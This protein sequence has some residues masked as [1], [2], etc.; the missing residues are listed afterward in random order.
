MF[1][2]RALALTLLVALPAKAQDSRL[3]SLQTGFAAQ[4][5]EAIGRLDMQGVGFCTATLIAPDRILTA[6]HCLY[7][8]RTGA[9]IPAE[10]L[11]FLAG[12]RT[13]RAEAERGINRIAI[14][15]RFDFASGAGMENV[16]EDIA[17]LELDRP[18][19]STTIRPFAVA[20]LPPLASGGSVTVVSY[21]RNRAEAPSI[22]ESCRILQQRPDG[23]SVFS[24]EIDYGSSGAP[25]LA[26]V[27]GERRIVSV[28]SARVESSDTPMSLGMRFAG[29]ELR[30]A[31]GARLDLGGALAHTTG[32]TIS[33]AIPLLQVISVVMML[34]GARGQGL[35]DAFLG[36]VA[37][38][39]RA[40]I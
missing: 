3:Q 5:W 35:T 25:V 33:L 28:I 15:P 8:R 2:I 37:L 40:A 7:D 32:Y 26:M 36:T 12:W 21:A 29:I 22:Q 17:V 34:T 39:R 1:L 19:R 4:G 27:N 9:R 30:D 6:A 24:C 20:D 10:R 13:G 18:V 16:S 14:W 31:Y 23:V 38:N 11:S